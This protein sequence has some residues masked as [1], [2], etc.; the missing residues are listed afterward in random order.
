MVI[1]LRRCVGCMSCQV[2][3]KMENNVPFDFFRSK[4]LITERGTYPDVK[5]RF[6]PVLCNHCEESPCVQVC[7]VGASYRRE[8]GVV[9][10]DQDKCIGC[11]YCVEACPYDARY[12][13][14][15][16][17]LADKCTF[18]QPRIDS[19]LEPACVHNCMGQA[20]IFGDLNDPNSAVAKLVSS[21]S[22]QTLKGN[23]GTEPH[24]FYISADLVTLDRKEGK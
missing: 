16:T 15:F 3:C 7:P 21:N 4:V 5:R 11:G 6:L 1:D 14:P 2:T 24:V 13:N 18:C 22:V 12:V 19:G 20:R 10:V 17:G 9:L 23:L 8:D